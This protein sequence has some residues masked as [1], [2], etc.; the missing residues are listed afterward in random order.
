MR[1]TDPYQNAHARKGLA[2]RASYKKPTVLF[3]VK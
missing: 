2:V 3:I 1:N